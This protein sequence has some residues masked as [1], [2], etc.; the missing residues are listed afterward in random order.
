M[1]LN[2]EHDVNW[3]KMDNLTV[4]I[5]MINKIQQESKQDINYSSMMNIEQQSI[6]KSI[7]PPPPSDHIRKSLQPFVGKR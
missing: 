2:G 7:I 4:A 6:G 5:A 1:V 3:E